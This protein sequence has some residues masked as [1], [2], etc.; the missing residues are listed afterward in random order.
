MGSNEGD[1]RTNLPVKSKK[2]SFCNYSNSELGGIR[3]YLVEFLGF[4]KLS[5][6]PRKRA[7]KTLRGRKQPKKYG[8]SF[9]REKK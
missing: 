7:L 1:S 5:Y 3:T 2:S 9:K 6:V 8:W 4:G